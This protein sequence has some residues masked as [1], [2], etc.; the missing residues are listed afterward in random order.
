VSVWQR[1]D[2]VT[3]DRWH[4]K[5][6]L[7]EVHD[8]TYISKTD[9]IPIPYPVAVTQQQTRQLTWWQETRIHFANVTLW[10]LL[11]FGVGWIFKKKF[12]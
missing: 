7:E 9:S 1:G 3:I 10:A 12:W 11:I 4:L 6:K 5:Y 8:T 2:T